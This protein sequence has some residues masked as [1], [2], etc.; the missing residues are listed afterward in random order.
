MNELLVYCTWVWTSSYNNSG[1]AGYIVKSKIDGYR[2]KFIFFPAAGHMGGLN[3]Y[4]TNK[5]GMYWTSSLDYESFASLRAAQLY[6]NDGSEANDYGTPPCSTMSYDRQ[7]GMS[8][9]PVINDNPLNRPKEW[10]VDGIE[11]DYEYVDLGL[12]VKWAT[13]NIGADNPKQGGY[14]YSWGE[15]ASKF[16]YSIKTYKYSSNGSKKMLKYN[17]EDGLTTLEPEDDAAYMNWGNKWRVPTN[18]E[19]EELIENCDWTQ[20]A[21]GGVCGTSKINGKKIIMSNMTGYRADGGYSSTTE[22]GH[23]WSSNNNTLDFYRAWSTIISYRGSYMYRTSNINRYDG[24]A[25]RPVLKE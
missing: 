20:N 1:I 5:M 16:E 11:Q 12:S 2:D 10:D 21:L 22:G 7:I 13:C 25:I 23:Y 24:L 18:A 19:F 8:I 4:D 14:L 6:F 17:K 9:R 3:Q 15:I